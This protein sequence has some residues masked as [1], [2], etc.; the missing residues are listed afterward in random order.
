MHAKHNNIVALSAVE[1]ISRSV[2]GV[3]GQ[4]HVTQETNRLY[5]DGQGRT[6]LESG[7]TVT[8]TDPVA[9]TTVRLDT[10][11][12]VF[13]KSAGGQRPDESRAMAEPATVEQRQLSSAPRHLGT[14]RFDGVLAEGTARTVT[15]RRDNAAP[16]ASEVTTWLATELQLAMHTKIVD[17]SGTV[18][19]KAYTDV[20]TGVALAADLFTVPPGYRAADPAAVAAVDCPLTAVPNPLFL[21]SFGPFLAF[22]SQV[23]VTDF[24]NAACLIV[25]T[26]A[27]VESPLWAFTTTPLGLPFFEWVF[28]DTGG[29]VPFLPWTAFGLSCYQA[30]NLEDTTEG[31]GLVVLNIWP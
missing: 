2:S 25:N 12:G 15:L 23:G 10:K 13:T 21:D 27:Y 8:I 19:E 9:R 14:A 18:Y 3:D 28:F 30:A 11:T 29:P 4:T 22:G 26:A 7:S 16:V 6:R 1:R 20:R 31:C 17:A 24:P 5:R